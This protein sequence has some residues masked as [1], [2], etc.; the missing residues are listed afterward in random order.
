M[1]AT[2]RVRRGAGPSPRR[3]AR[4]AAVPRLR[5]AAQQGRRRVPGAA[6]AAL[7][8]LAAVAIPGE[9]GSLSADEAAAIAAPPGID[10]AAAAE[11]RRSAARASPL[12]ADAPARVL[13]CG[14]LYLA[15]VVLAANEDD[16]KG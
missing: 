8:R 13:I 5:H 2:I 14:S 16:L 9:E 6:G 1:A 12:P 10:A 4:P 7:A 15:G 3:L 11:R